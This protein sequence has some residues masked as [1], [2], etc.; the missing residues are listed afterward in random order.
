[1]A[2]THSERK[3]ALHFGAE[4]KFYFSLSHQVIIGPNAAF[5]TI[6]LGATTGESVGAKQLMIPSDADTR[7]PG[8]FAGVV[9]AGCGPEFEWE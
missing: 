1:M 3:F 7:R 8:K 6:D 5:A 4:L 9:N 2:L